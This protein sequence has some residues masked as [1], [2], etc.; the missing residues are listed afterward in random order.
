MILTNK[1]WC[2][3]VTYNVWKESS[4]LTILNLVTIFIRCSPTFKEVIIK[5]TKQIISLSCLIKIDSSSS[6]RSYKQAVLH[7]A[8]ASLHVW[9]YFYN[10]NGYLV[11]NLSL[12]SLQTRIITA[13]CKNQ[14]AV[15]WTGLSRLTTRANVF[16]DRIPSAQLQTGYKEAEYFRERS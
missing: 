15:H 11:A 10:Q 7:K 5:S 16:S 1:P 6:L 2:M 13:I 9:R 8:H 14:K 12:K 3:N 4:K